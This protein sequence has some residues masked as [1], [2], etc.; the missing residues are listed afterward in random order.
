MSQ[1]SAMRPARDTPRVWGHGER[2]ILGQQSD[3]PVHVS[4]L[5]RVDEALDDLAHA[6]VAERAQSRLLT[7]FGHPL[8]HGSTGA[9]ERTVHGWDGHSER[10]RDLLGGETKDLTEN[11]HCPLSRRQA[12]NGRNEREL[13]RLALLVAG[14][15]CRIALFEAQHLVGVGLH[16]GRTSQPFPCVTVV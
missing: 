10:P 7:P 1:Q 8:V 3:D 16:P 11:E 9:L 15:G 13:D 14:L 2:R 12:L 6:F 4:A 5:E